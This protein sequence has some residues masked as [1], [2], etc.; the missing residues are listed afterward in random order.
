MSTTPAPLTPAEL[1]ALRIAAI[2]EQ[3]DAVKA[4]T[5]ELIASRAAAQEVMMAMAQRPAGVSEDFVLK[6]A[7]VIAALVA[8]KP[9]A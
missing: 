9:A 4:Q 8:G 5:A 3:I 2:R 7:G 6:L 1:D